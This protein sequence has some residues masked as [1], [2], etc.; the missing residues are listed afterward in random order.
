MDE[1]AKI[2]SKVGSQVGSTVENNPLK[3][4]LAGAGGLETLLAEKK[5]Q[6]ILNRYMNLANNPAAS[7]AKIRSM[8]QPLDQALTQSVDNSVQGYLGE[9]GLSESPQISE[10]VLAQTLAP[11]AQKNTDAAIQEYYD[12]LGLGLNAEKQNAPTEPDLSKLLASLE[13]PSSSSVGSLPTTG[14]G[15]VWSEIFNSLGS[16]G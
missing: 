5:K 6:D 14:S 3:S 15:D 2:L 16:T 8:T 7:E 13:S 10:A 11:Y 1:F 12:S 4:V 9:R